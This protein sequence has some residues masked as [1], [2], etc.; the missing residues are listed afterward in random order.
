MDVDSVPL[1]IDF[2]KHLREAVAK[3]EVLLAVIGPNWLDLRDERGARR[4]DDPNDFVRIEIGTALQRQILEIRHVS[5]HSDMDK[6]I[7]ALR[8]Q[9]AGGRTDKEPL[10]TPNRSRM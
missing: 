8:T 1:G 10:T 4:L 5:F 7:T 2:V 6:L 3:C 9:L